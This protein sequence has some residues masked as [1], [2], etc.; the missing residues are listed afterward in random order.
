MFKKKTFKLIAA[1]LICQAAGIIGSFFT[2]PSIKGWYA[3]LNKPSF[4]PP[5]WIFGPVWTSLFLLMG[6]SLYLVWKSQKGRKRSIALTTFSVQLVLNIIWS[7]LFFELN[8]PLCAFIEIIILWLAIA[9][10]IY[11]FAKINKKAAYLL[12]PYLFWVSFAMILNFSI[13]ILN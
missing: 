11:Y 12:L 2:T 8:C 4:N 9:L 1:I 10:T 3:S 7:F 5:N 13:W 6:I